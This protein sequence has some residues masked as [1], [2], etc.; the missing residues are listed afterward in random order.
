MGLT[1]FR[2]FAL[3]VALS[4]VAAASCPAQEWVEFVHRTDRFAL[5]FPAVSE[6][7]ETTHVPAHGV[8]FPT[9]IYSVTDGNH[10]YSLTVADYTDAERRHRDRP[11]MTDV[12][13]TS[14]ADPQD[15]TVRVVVE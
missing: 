14:L 15:G 9:R 13:I 4:Y 10:L 2:K 11:D 1:R 3:A 6:I 12:R 7:M 5:T 8:V